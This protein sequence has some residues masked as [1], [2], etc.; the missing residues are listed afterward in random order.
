MKRA[1]TSY[2]VRPFLQNK[3]TGKMLQC[4]KPKF[5]STGGREGTKGLWEISYFLIS[6]KILRCVRFVRTKPAEHT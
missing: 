6:A 5:W 3:S 1:F 4:E 2:Q